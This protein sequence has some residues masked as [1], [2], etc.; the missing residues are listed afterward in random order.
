M[1][2][3]PNTIFLFVLIFGIGFF[4]KNIR[5]IFHNINLGKKSKGMIN[6]QFDLKE[7]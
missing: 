3:L 5:R 1:A 7:C 6:H 2:Y 4:I